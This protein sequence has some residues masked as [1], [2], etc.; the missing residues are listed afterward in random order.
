MMKRWFLLGLLVLSIPA[1]GLFVFGQPCPT[2]VVIIPE[3]V[4]IHLAPEPVPDPAAETAII[5]H[6]LNYGFH[7]VDQHQV[8]AIRL[9]DP[10]LVER[11]FE[12]DSAAIM[13]LSDRFVADIL[14]I[15]EAFAEVEE[16]QGVLD[17][18]PARARVEVRAIETATGRILAA[19]AI[20]TGGIDF[21]LAAAGKKALQRGGDAIAY[22]LAKAIARHIPPGCVTVTPPL[23]R[24][25]TI[26]VTT[27]EDRS[28]VRLGDIPDV[29]TTMVGTSLSE[30]GYRTVHAMAGDLV[31]TGVI[32]DYKQILTPVLGI[33]WLDWLWRAGT[34][35][36]TVDVQVFDLHT[37]ELTAYEVTANVSGVEI[38][39]FRFGFSPRDLARAVSKQIAERMDAL[40]R[41][42]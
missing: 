20:H 40:Y 19:E 27:F 24:A 32:T 11:A 34:A 1:V 37:G 16:V 8:R 22:Q 33:P 13:A 10:E 25:P 36:M 3:W 7:V 9:S 42:R 26:G 6:F 30:R 17:L 35:W 41:R 18:Q 38:F 31:V 29:L 2:V 14:V 4:I 23:L 21:T 12:G 5:H 39:G 15:G 28:G